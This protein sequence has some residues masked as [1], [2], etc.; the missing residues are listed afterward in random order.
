MIVRTADGSSRSIS[1]EKRTGNRI[2]GVVR[3]AKATATLR[4]TPLA[5]RRPDAR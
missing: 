2:A 4:L 3:R 5:L 1:M